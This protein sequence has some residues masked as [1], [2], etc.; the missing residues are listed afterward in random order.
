LR[1]SGDFAAAEDATQEAL[2]A[3]TT[4]WPTV[5]VPENPVGWLIR[6]AERRWTDQLRSDI[7]RRRR[8]EQVTERQTTDPVERSSH[9]DTLT[10][11]FMCC[12]AALSEASAI[13]LTLRAVGG[14]SARE[15][16]RAF[17]VP[18]TTMAQRISRAKRAIKESNVPFARPEGA[19][20]ASRLRAI[21]HVLYLIF[22]E[23]YLASAGPELT[24]VDLSVEAI[25]LGRIVHAALPDDPE[26]GGLLAL[27]LLTEARRPARTGLDGELIPLPEQ[28]RTLWDGTMI[29]EGLALIDGAW[30]KGSVGA[31]QV[32]AAIAA[33]HDQA[34]HVDQ[35]D[36]PEILALYELHERLADSPVVKLNKA[37]AVAMVHGPSTG[38]AALDALT[39]SPGERHRVQSVRGHL[40]EML[41]DTSAAIASYQDAAAATASVPEQKFLLTHAGRLARRTN[42]QQATGSRT[43]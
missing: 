21:L 36:W 28:D 19:L 37:V 2:L 11:M 14:L 34:R 13:A 20:W 42:P 12:H 3:A 40:L 33:I 32:Q 17:L 39:V 16:A 22:N 26:V 43:R 29:R 25:R 9:D 24:R 7:A 6:V 18:E 31:Y 15:I 35:T 27:M 41:G 10:L 23:G 1:R 8:E 4:Q 38:L 5:G 30:G